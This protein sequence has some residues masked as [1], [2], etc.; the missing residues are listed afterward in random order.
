MKILM[1][2]LRGRGGEVGG[3][4]SWHLR[5]EVGDEHISNAITSVMK[6]YLLIEIYENDGA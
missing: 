6:D 2:A 3:K 4:F 5:L 1:C